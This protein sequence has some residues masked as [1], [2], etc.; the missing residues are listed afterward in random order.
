MKPSPATTLMIC[1]AVDVVELMVRV[2]VCVC[3]CVCGVQYSVLTVL[4]V[5]AEIAGI[6]L[7]AGVRQHVRTHSS[8]VTFTRGTT[9][10]ISCIP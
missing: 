9:P 4:V 5:V 2:C 6:A 1:D 10:D 7:F 8:H 3:V